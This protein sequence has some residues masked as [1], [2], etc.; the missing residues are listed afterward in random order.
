[1]A[2][3]LDM[4]VG[5]AILAGVRQGGLL[6]SMLFA[7]YTDNLICRLKESGLG[8]KLYDSYFCCLV[9]A[10]DII[11]ILRSVSATQKMLHICDQF[12][13]DFDVKFNTSK[14]V[15]MLIGKRHEA[16]CATMTLSGNYLEY[17]QSV[18]YLGIHV[19]ASKRFK[20]T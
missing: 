2:W 18:K 6:S 17:V 14:S 10:D 8:C 1:L 20:C 9:Y 3:V 11:L 16:K 19:K 5:Q 4:G 12:A 7:M 15:A 13:V